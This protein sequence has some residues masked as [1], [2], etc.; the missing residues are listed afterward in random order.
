MFMPIQRRQRGFT[1]VELMMVV[2][3]VGVLMAVA[4]PAYDSYVR[5]SKVP[6]GLDAL[7]SLATRLEQFYQDTG[8]YGTASC[9]QGMT[10]P[11]PAYYTV[12]C[13][14]TG[15]GQ[16]FTATATATINGKTYTYTINNQGTRV[17]TAHPNGVP[18]GNCWS[19]KGGSCDS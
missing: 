7:S 15:S 6:A 9:G 12:T 11:T 18:T 1:M 19:I 4:L 10:M 16:G 14:L 3:I 13:S 17:T 5:R 8:A 2:A